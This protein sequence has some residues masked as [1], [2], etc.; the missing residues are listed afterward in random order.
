MRFTRFVCIHGHFYQPPRESAWTDRLGRQPSARPYHDWNDRI[1]AECYGPNG[2]A[3]IL[4]EKDRIVRVVNNYARTSFNFGPTL[5]SWM[6]TEAPEAYASILAADA[7][8]AA[9]FSGH[10]SAMAQAY[11]HA[12]MPLASARDQRTQVRWGVRDF[13]RRFGRRPEGMW[14]PEA[15]VDTAS[16]EALADAGI[17]FTVLSPRQAA[18]FTNPAG[19]TTAATEANLDTGRAYSVAL[20]SGRSIAV[21]FYD[22]AVSQAVAFERLL[23]DGAGFARRLLGAFRTRED[24]TEAN[25]VHIATDGETYGHHHRFGEMALAW[26]T[27]VIRRDPSIRLTNYGEFL[28]TAPPTWKASIVERSAWSCFHGVGRWTDDCGCRMRGG[29]SQA[30]RRPL[31]DALD[32]LRAELDALFEAH[33]PTVLREPWAARDDYVDVVLDRSPETRRRFLEAHAA[34]PLDDAGVRRA[35]TLLESQRFGMLMYTS[36]GWFFDDLH[37]IETIQIM[38]YA[39]RAAELAREIDGR[40]LLGK[41]LTELER[42]RNGPTEPTGRVLL[43]KRMGE[44]RATDARI[45]AHAAMGALFEPGFPSFESRVHDVARGAVERTAHAGFVCASGRVTIHHRMTGREDVRSFVA[46]RA[47]A[48]SALPVEPFTAAI[49]D[50]PDAEARAHATAQATR[51]ASGADAAR[52][53]L[54][55]AGAE[56]FDSLGALLPDEQARFIGARVSAIADDVRARFRA[57]HAE[58]EPALL[59]IA[60]LSMDPPKIL[61][62]AS[63]LVLGDD[64][65][66]ALERE[67][68]DFRRL[69]ELVSTASAEDVHLDRAAL[70]H[71]ASK[72]V[73]RVARTLGRASSWEDLVAALEIALALSKSVDVRAAEDVVWELLARGGTALDGAARQAVRLLRLAPE[74]LDPG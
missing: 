22:G 2:R 65:L 57:I 44:A 19:E 17:A 72:M 69:A 9:R 18:S 49:F 37:G 24:A 45:A 60:P 14:L 39:V 16:L 41:F 59:Q 8:S 11:N 62:A 48:G 64:I 15:A 36:C 13:E 21:F 50:G 3:R 29:S 25:L 56:T 12:I 27:E 38:E 43:E 67:A 33:G 7:E 70:A 61:V 20:P 1:T 5:L 71:A 63:K 52:E 55:R 34:G 35:L 47:E 31:R 10:G 6:E 53:S 23:S 30:W 51:L 74:P 4:D 42:A 68:P 66:F 26:A 58:C 40:D 28:A 73:S 46:V 54:V 32:L